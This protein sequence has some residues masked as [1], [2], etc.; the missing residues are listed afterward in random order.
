[1][2]KSILNKF[3]NQDKYIASF[4]LK[5]LGLY[6][7]WFLVYD[8]WLLKDGYVDQF[9]IQHLVKSTELVLQFLGYS[10]FRYADAVGI[11]GTHGVLIGAPCNGL[12]LFALFMGFILIFPGKWKHKAFFI[13]LGILFIHLLNIVRLVG[14][15]IV[16]FYSPDYLEFNHKYTFTVIVYAFIFGMWIIWFNKFSTRK[17]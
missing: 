16:V 14:L 15:A 2:L 13:P 6:V 9:L 4:I 1:M 7:I 5:G 11:D 3:S 12:D 10:T 8:N 17:N